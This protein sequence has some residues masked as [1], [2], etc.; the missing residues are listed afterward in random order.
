MA[1]VWAEMQARVEELAGQARLQI[2]RAI[3]ENEVTHQAGPPHRPNP[4]AVCAAANSQVILGNSLNLVS[5]I[6]HLFSSTVVAS[7]WYCCVNLSILAIS[8][9]AN[10]ISRIG[11]CTVPANN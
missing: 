11:D 2:L 4:S 10:D 3:L 1:D 5:V 6:R 8:S 7:I 9:C